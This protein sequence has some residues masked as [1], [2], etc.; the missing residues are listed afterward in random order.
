MERKT[1][2]DN[3]LH[4][5][6]VQGGLAP[7]T[8]HGFVRSLRAFASWLEAEGYTEDNIFKAIK[9]PKIPQVLMQPLTED[10]IRRILVIIPQDTVEGIR[11]YAIV[12][13]FLDCGIRLSELIKHTL[14]GLAHCVKELF[15]WLRSQMRQ[16]RALSDS[17]RLLGNHDESRQ[18]MH[19][20]PKSR[21]R[22]SVSIMQTV[23]H[24]QV[25]PTF[26]LAR[27]YNRSQVGQF[28]H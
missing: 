28:S 11:N 10:E 2:Y 21:A 13:T 18:P 17:W 15:E 22:L 1:R 3:H 9:P 16:P 12:L 5:D 4:R 23:K 7:Q 24:P 25:N 14:T 26:G 6:Q 19:M 27:V 20:H 8:I